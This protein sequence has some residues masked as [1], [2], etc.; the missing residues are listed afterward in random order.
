MI[1]YADSKRKK[2]KNERVEELE[3]DSNDANETI[4]ELEDKVSTLQK[5]LNYFKGLW[6]KFIK[7]LWNKFFSLNKHIYFINYLY[8]E[9]IIDDNEIYIIQN[10]KINDKSDGFE[11]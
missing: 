3:Y 6:E 9:D 8:D 4:D 10:N 5:P 1:S 7:F 11:R 2:H